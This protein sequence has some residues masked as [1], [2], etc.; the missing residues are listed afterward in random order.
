MNNLQPQQSLWGPGPGGNRHQTPES[1]KH[2]I[3]NFEGWYQ[4]RPRID[5]EWFNTGSIW[6]RLPRY[7]ED[8]PSAN[9]PNYLGHFCKHVFL[10]DLV[11]ADTISQGGHISLASI[12]RDGTL[13]R[14]EGDG[15][16]FGGGTRVAHFMTGY[17]RVWLGGTPPERSDDPTHMFPELL[18]RLQLLTRPEDPP[19]PPPEELVKKAK[20]KARKKRK[21]KPKEKPVH[22]P[23][24][25]ELLM[26]DDEDA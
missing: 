15:F 7:P 14:Y 12:E 23:S 3:A 4:P 18:Y 11:V 21:R 22:R 24:V 2:S 9:S 16:S 13:E 26:A 17:V 10:D 5:I 25:W 6:R 1:T 19:P 20:K 8:Y